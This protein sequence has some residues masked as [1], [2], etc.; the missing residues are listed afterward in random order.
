MTT[1]QTIV[2]CCSLYLD[3]PVIRLHHPGR[4][5]TFLSSRSCFISGGYNAF[6]LFRFMDPMPADQPNPTP[7]PVEPV[8]APTPSPVAKATEAPAKAPTPS[9]EPAPTPSPVAK[10]TPTPVKAPTPSPEPAPTPSPVAKPTPTPVKAPTPSPVSAPT[11]TPVKPESDDGGGGGGS[12]GSFDDTQYKGE[13]TY[14]GATTGG[15]CAFGTNIPS[16]YDGMIP[17]EHLPARRGS[18]CKGGW[19]GGVGMLHE[20]SG[21]VFG[22]FKSQPLYLC[23]WSHL[24]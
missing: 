16:M 7:S 4:H 3:P 20:R 11:P 12:E 5:A 22:G 6:S 10:P 19:G 9:P 15:N 24:L 13:G 18:R 1:K 17:G 23:L 8:A 14:Y 2:G 21:G